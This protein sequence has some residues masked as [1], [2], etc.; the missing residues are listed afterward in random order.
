MI[1]KERTEWFLKGSSHYFTHIIGNMYAEK[2]PMYF[3][4]GFPRS[5]TSWFSEMLA[6]YLN[7]PRP[8]HYYLPIAFPSVVQTHAKPTTKVK[9]CFYIYRDGRDVYLSFYFLLLKSLKNKNHIYYDYWVK[10]FGNNFAKQDFSIC[11]PIYL[12]TELKKKW[13]WQS[14]T[15]KWVEK[16]Y[17]GNSVVTVK[18]EDLLRDTRLT[19]SSTLAKKVA[20]INS[21]IVDEVVSNYEF[22]KQKNRPVEQHLTPMGEGKV[23]KW[24]DHYNNEC[25]EIFN[26][27]AGDTLKS[28]GYT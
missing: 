19:L 25:I 23:G 18:Y 5:G 17:E 14:H 13:S 16:S 27:Y 4:C 12:E 3:V 26:H 7:L 11:F 2:L 9:N 8:K 22:K 1:S 6:G 10:R 24:E 20:P 21:T 28:L 15:S